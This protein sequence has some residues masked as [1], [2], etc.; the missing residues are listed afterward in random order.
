MNR[1][2]AT[3]FILLLLTS[4]T[5][6][7]EKVPSRESVRYLTIAPETS[8][9]TSIVDH[10]SEGLFGG[11]NAG[12][13][14]IVRNANRTDTLTQIVTAKSSGVSTTFHG[15]V[16]CDKGDVLAL[17]YPNENNSSV[18]NYDALGV[19]DLN[20][21]GQDGTLE[22]ISQK[23]DFCTAKAQVTSVNGFYATASFGTFRN[24]A[25][26]LRFRLNK[27][28]EYLSDITSFTIYSPDLTPVRT[29]DMVAGDFTNAKNVSSFT[30][31]CESLRDVY[32]VLFPE[33]DVPLTITAISGGIE[34]IGI[35]PA[36]TYV[37]GGYYMIELIVAGGD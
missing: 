16:S 10:E 4:C 21:Y 27:N 14:L 8:T 31:K 5:G 6:N 19:V 17:F 11:W 2:F 9:R 32:V 1:L 13:R 3:S 26:I 24:L 15:A 22:T 28:G 20:I 23:Y 7:E 30:M 25:A 37:E 29:F 12:D 36:A 34:Y 18:Q 33:T 35:V